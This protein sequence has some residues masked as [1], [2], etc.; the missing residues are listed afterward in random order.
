MTTAQ[1]R[2]AWRNYCIK[3]LEQFGVQIHR[4][5]AGSFRLIGLHGDI[6][7]T[8]LADLTEFELFGFARI[9]T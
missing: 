1:K 7:M 2:E 9:R 6:T 8:D 5:D 4:T 3:V